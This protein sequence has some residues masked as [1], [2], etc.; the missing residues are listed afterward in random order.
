MYIASSDIRNGAGGSGV[1]KN[2]DTNSGIISRLT[3]NGNS[4]TKVD[5]IR[6]LPRSEEIHATNG[7]QIDAAT[8][9]MYITSGGHTNAGSPSNNF[10]FSTEYALSAAI[11]EVD[12]DAIENMSIK[13][14]NG[15]AYIYDI[16]TVDDP[17]RPNQNGQ[18]INDPF[19]GNDG[20]NQA[21][22]VP[23]CLL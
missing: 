8:N 7:I 18:D 14:D 9:N 16:P 2:L 3:K 19:G 4:W 13:N 21:K 5:I 12:L 6:G 10:T 22:I 1:D 15:S 11:L 23:G 17:T 20:L